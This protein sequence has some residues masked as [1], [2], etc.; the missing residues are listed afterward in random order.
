MNL[1]YGDQ[2]E[3][4]EGK[5]DVEEN[6]QVGCKGVRR[7]IVVRGVQVV[8]ARECKVTLTVYR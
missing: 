7:L 1:T 5:C 4:E 8:V 2:K 6:V 3:S